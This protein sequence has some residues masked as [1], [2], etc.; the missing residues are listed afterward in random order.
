[1]GRFEMLLP[2]SAFSPLVRRSFSDEDFIFDLSLVNDLIGTLLQY[3]AHGLLELR[4]P[5]AFR[6]VH[7]DPAEALQES[8]PNFP[9]RLASVRG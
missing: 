3:V 2:N 4:E 8:S 6:F 9:T 1:M 5:D 7:D